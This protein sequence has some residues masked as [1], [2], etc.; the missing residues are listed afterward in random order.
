MIHVYM[1]INGAWTD[2][3]QENTHMLL[4]PLALFLPFKFGMQC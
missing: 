1:S 2:G 3:F 4:L